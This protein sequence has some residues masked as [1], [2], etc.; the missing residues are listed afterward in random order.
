MAVAAVYVQHD[1]LIWLLLLKFFF[2]VLFHSSLFPYLVQYHLHD[3]DDDDDSDGTK[4]NRNRERAREVMHLVSDLCARLLQFIFYDAFF[5]THIH[6]SFN[7][8]VNITY[9]NNI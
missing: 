6:L 5:S 2:F 7:F 8:L 1:D 4:K 9:Y 3:D